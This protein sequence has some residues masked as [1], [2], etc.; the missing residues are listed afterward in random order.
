MDWLALKLSLKLA[1][2]TMLI[3]HLGIWVGR[4]LAWHR[5][6][7]RVLVEALLALPLYFAHGTEVLLAG[8]AG[9]GISTRPM[10]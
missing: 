10:V 5:F 7:G 9:E 1:L 6:R 8:G 4:K 3:C 2:G